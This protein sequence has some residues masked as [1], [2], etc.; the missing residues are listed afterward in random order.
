MKKYPALILALVMVFSLC[1]CGSSSNDN[2]DSN[3][4]DNTAN[5]NGGAPNGEGEMTIADL[6]T[7]SLD[8]PVDTTAVKEAAQNGVFKIGVILLH[9][10]Q[11][12]Y[13]FAHITGIKAAQEAL[14]LSDD[15]I[16][17]KYNIPEDETCYDTAVDLAEQGCKLIFADSFGHESYLMQAAGEY[18]DVIFAHASGQSAATSSLTNFVNYFT[19]VY[20]SRYVSGV[21]AGMKLKQLMD[22]G[23]V[24]DP[25][26]G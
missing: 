6:I 21:V 23:E 2:Q 15:Q 10:E 24:T 26:V 1:A 16:I 19:Q 22:S 9:N 18:P 5:D 7:A 17:W 14:G 8:K 11:I 13:D 3:E 20:Q 12:G 25:C 4:S